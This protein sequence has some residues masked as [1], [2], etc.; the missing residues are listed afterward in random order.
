ME[1][2]EQSKCGEPGASVQ[3]INHKARLLLSEIMQMAQHPDKMEVISTGVGRRWLPPQGEVLKV[4]TDG[5]FMAKDKRGAWGFVIID[6]EGHGVLAGVGH[7]RAVHNAL[8]AER[9][10]CLAALQAAL[11]AGISRI[12][13]ETGSLLLVKAIRTCE[14]DYGLGGVIF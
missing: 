4:N 5:A 10:S 9:E 12:I 11:E 13:I 7:L 6:S 1:W 3:E 8:S 2:T 14:L